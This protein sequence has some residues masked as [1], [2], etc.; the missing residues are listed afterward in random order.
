MTHRWFYTFLSTINSLQQQQTDDSN[1]HYLLVSVASELANNLCHIRKY[2]QIIIHAST[3]HIWISQERKKGFE[4]KFTTT[5]QSW[6]VTKSESWVGARKRFRTGHT[7]LISVR[8]KHKSSFTYSRPK[9]VGDT[10]GIVLNLKII[11]P[12]KNTLKI[13]ASYDE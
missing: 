9:K 13:L 5:S 11:E 4:L 1:H 3:G 6:T 2:L 10:S 7:I 8:F 12:N